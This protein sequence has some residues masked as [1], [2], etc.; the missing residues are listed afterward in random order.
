MIDSAV[1]LAVSRSS[2]V[3]RRE[4]VDQLIAGL[5][6]VAENDRD[7][8]RDHGRRDRT[9]QQPAAAHG[10]NCVSLLQRCGLSRGAVGNASAP[11]GKVATSRRDWGLFA[12]DAFDRLAQ[13]LET[14]PVFLRSRKLGLGLGELG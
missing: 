4:R 2:S 8:E 9:F 1:T 6:C 7:R 13:H 10:D 11:I 14:E 3:S 5:E 12:S